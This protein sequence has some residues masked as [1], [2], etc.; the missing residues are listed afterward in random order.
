[1][2]EFASGAVTRSLSI[3]THATLCWWNKNN[4]SLTNVDQS[5]T[6]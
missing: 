2:S 5:R 4:N 3:L 6:K 1:V